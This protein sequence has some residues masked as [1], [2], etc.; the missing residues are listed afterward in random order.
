MYIQYRWILHVDLVDRIRAI[1]SY[2]PVETYNVMQR[3]GKGGSNHWIR[4]VQHSEKGEIAYKKGIFWQF[5]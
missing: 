1:C 4:G 2:T 5:I 3:F